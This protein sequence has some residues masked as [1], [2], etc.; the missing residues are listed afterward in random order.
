MKGVSKLHDTG[1]S[2]I[3]RSRVVPLARVAIIKSPRKEDSTRIDAVHVIEKYS[4]DRAKKVRMTPTSAYLIVKAPLS[5]GKVWNLA[6]REHLRK[7][8]RPV[9]LGTVR[10]TA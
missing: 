10:L 8:E 7:V 2:L 6:K 1:T 5:A 9:A 3:Q 4:Y